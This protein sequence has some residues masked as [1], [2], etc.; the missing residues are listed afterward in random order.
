MCAVARLGHPL[1]EA[2]KLTLAHLE[3]AAWIVP[4]VGSVLRHRFDLMFQRASLR[5]PSNVV[6]TSAIMLITRLI[7]QSD[8]LAILAAEVAHY[9][10]AAGVIAT[11][12][13]DIPCTMDDFGI[14]TRN[15]HFLTP[16]AQLLADALRDT[17][18]QSHRL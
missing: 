17:A 5:P 10:A 7:E 12:P 11:L 14:I 2:K 13:L 4:P 9:Y 6:E 16:A 8:M 18:L 15:D 3:K 1:F